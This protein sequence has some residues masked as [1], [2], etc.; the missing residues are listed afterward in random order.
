[1]GLLIAECEWILSYSIKKSTGWQPSRQGNIRS[2]FE[3]DFL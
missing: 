2:L 3:K 1:L